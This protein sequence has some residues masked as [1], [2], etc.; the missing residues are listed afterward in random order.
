MNDKIRVLFVCLGNICR[1]PLAEGVFAGLVRER[2]LDNRI[3]CDSAGTS[4][5][6]IGDR[7]DPRTIET[8]EKH[9][10]RLDHLGRKFVSGDFQRFDYILAMDRQ[11]YAD[12]RSVPGYREYDPERLKLM[13]DYDDREPGGDVPDPYYGGMD[14]FEQVY[15]I[16][17]RS[18]GRL[19]DDIVR[20]NGL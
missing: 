11:N 17:H 14:G 18:C 6:H 5:W 15:G 7:P 4:G 19:L 16:L 3:A 12:I 1:S 20:Q 8:A 10:L 9:G 2:G 13:R